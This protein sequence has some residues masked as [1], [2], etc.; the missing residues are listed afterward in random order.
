MIRPSRGILL[1]LNSP[2][3][4]HAQT[5]VVQRL[6]L[7]TI[8]NSPQLKHQLVPQPAVRQPIRGQHSSSGRQRLL[9]A[10]QRIF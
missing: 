7:L 6:K 9:H 8:R 4:Y 10:P 2:S 5:E 3:A 1:L